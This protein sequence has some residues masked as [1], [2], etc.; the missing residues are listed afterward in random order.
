[1][2][3]SAL[4]LTACGGKAGISGTAGDSAGR[5]LIVKRLDV[6]RFTTLDT[7][8]TSD[9]GSFHYKVKVDKGDPE[10]IYIFSGDRQLAALLLDR[11][12]KVVVKA[13]TLGNYSVEG[14]E[15]SAKLST[16]EQSYRKFASDMSAATD[17]PQMAGIYLNHYRENVRFLLENPFSLTTVPVLYQQLGEATPI[18]NQ[19]TDAIFF[20]N[21]ADSLETVYPESRYVKALRR[22]AERRMKLLEL[23]GQLRDAGEVSYPDIKL[24]DINGN[25]AALSAVDSRVVLVHF[26]D[27]TDASQKMMNLDVLLPLYKEYHDKGFEIY[28]VC[29]TS[30]KAGWGSVVNAQGLPWINVCDIQGSA[31]RYA[32]LYNVTGLPDSILIA[33]GEISTASGIKG[34]DGLRR[35]LGRLLGRR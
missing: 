33:D 4:M 21:A 31:S 20:R 18:F 8:K 9:G 30:D 16:V 27:C 24:P 7:I 3:A 26:W 23:D 10:F 5:E 6:N 28:A 19:P 32:S 29:L 11:G 34:A 14:S 12:D 2:L 25:T 35:E 22:E 1:M 15:E 17:G 13:D